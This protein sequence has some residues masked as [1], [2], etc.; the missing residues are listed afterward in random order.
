M[1]KNLQ[2]I[3]AL[4]AVINK[5]RNQPDPTGIHGKCISHANKKMT[6]IVEKILKEK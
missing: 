3:Y 1:T 5:H 4:T 6:N 2:Q